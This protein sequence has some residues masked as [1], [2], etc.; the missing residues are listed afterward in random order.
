MKAETEMFEYFSL[1]VSRVLR[2]FV[3]T[4]F[5]SMISFSTR[6]SIRRTSFACLLKKFQTSLFGLFGLFLCICY[7][8]SLFAF[9]IYRSKRYL[10]FCFIVDLSF[11]LRHLQTE[12]F[13]FSYELNF[14]CDAAA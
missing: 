6:Q 5:E 11:F 1:N 7:E 4:E 10:K 3:E 2:T 12:R 14:N 8:I 13:F 9:Y